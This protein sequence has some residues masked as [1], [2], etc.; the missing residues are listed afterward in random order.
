MFAGKS[1]S[2]VSRRR[3]RCSTTRSAVVKSASPASPR[4]SRTSSAVRL[5]RFATSNTNSSVNARHARSTGP[6]NADV[7]HSARCSACCSL[8]PADNATGER[9]VNS[10]A[11]PSSIATRSRASSNRHGSTLSHAASFAVSS[12]ASTS[13]CPRKTSI[14]TAEVSGC[15][16]RAVPTH[17]TVQ[18]LH[19][20]KRANIELGNRNHTS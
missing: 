7:G 16:A 4:Y 18:G 20:P 6:N 17:R 19:F 14:R 1:F 5:E 2:H 12:A 13:G 3:W 10:A 9:C 11:Q 15:A 8:K